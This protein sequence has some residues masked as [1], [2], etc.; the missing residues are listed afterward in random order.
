VCLLPELV[1]LTIDFVPFTNAYRPGHAKLK[2]RW[3]LYVLGSWLFGTA[4]VRLERACTDA[5]S[6][7][8]LLACGGVAILAAEVTWR[9]RA[10]R[11]SV[12]PREEFA[13]DGSDIAVLDIG[14]VVHGAHVRG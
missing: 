5:A 13:D 9:T 7:V 10:D 12:E 14:Q 6:F 1:V 8:A 4:L 11:W 2:T 3:P